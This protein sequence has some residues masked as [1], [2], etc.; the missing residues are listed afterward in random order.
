MARV[1]DIYA[2]RGRMSDAAPYW[3]RMAEVHPGDPNGYLQSAT[4]YWD[5]FDFDS[6]LTQLQKGR[7][8]LA[9]PALY[10]YE[11]GAI[12]ETQGQIAEAIREYAAGSLASDSSVDSRLRFIELAGRPTFRATVD[13][14][15]QGLLKSGT[16]TQA[17]IEL[18]IAVL[19][20]THRSGEVATEL[21]EAISKADSFAVLNMLADTAQTRGLGEVQEAAVN[22]QIALS[23]DPIRKI[24]LQYQLVDLMSSRDA[25]AATQQVDAIYHEHPKVLGV[26]RATVDYDWDHLRRQQAVSVLLEAAQSSYPDLKD[27]FV[28]EAGRKLTDLGDYGRAGKLLSELLARNVMDAGVET[29]LANNYAHSGDKAGLE[30]FYKDRLLVVK[31]SALQG[32]EKADRIAQLRRGMIPAAE[33]LGEWDEVADQYIE[34]IN[35]FPGDADLVQEAALTAG[36]H[37]QGE[38]LTGF[39]RRTIQKS[40]QDARWSIVL[41]ELETGLENFSAAVDAYGLA[42]HVRPEQ[43]DLYSSHAELCERLHRLDVA[44]ADYQ[45]LYRLSYRDP[46]WKI[47]EAEARAR[48]GR[49]ADVVKALEEAWIQGHPAN[50]GDQFRVAQQLEQ[51]N[52]L[53]EARGYAERGADMAGPAWLVDAN[54]RQGAEVYARIMA[55]LRHTDDGFARLAKARYQAEQLAVDTG[56]NSLPDPDSGI[57]IDEWR[58][59]L[60]AERRENIRNVFAV[61]LKAIGTVVAQYDTPEEKLQ[62]S[63]WLQGHMATASD[64][65]ELRS[66][67]LPTIQAAGLK[68]LEVD[69]LWRFALASKT[70]DQSEAQQWLHLQRSRGQIDGG[71]KSLEDLAAKYQGEKRN[72]LLKEALQV[73]Q[74]LNDRT[75]ELRVLTALERGHSGGSLSARHFDLLFGAR[76]ND[77]VARS[78]NDSVA[79]RLVESGRAELAL[80]AIQVRSVGL[81]PVWKSAYTGLV[82][83]YL[84]I[85]QPAIHQGFEDALATEMTIGDRLDHTPERNRQLA[86]DLWYYYGSRYGEYLD[87]EKDPRAEGLLEAALEKAPRDPAA[88]REL[89]NFNAEAGHAEPAL[90]DYR[91]SL[92]LNH[93]QPAVLNSMAVL[94][95]K[96]GDK[97]AAAECWKQAIQLLSAEMDSRRVPESFWDDFAD[98]LEGASAHGSYSEISADVDNMLR[99]Y[100]KRNGSYRSEPLLKAGYEANGQSLSWLLNLA[101]QIREKDDFGYLL[102][103]LSQADWIK[104]EHKTAVLGHIVENLRSRSKPGEEAYELESAEIKWMNALLQDHQFAQARAELSRI[105]PADLNKSGWV[106][107]AL[108]LADADKGLSQILDT[109]KKNPESAPETEELQTVALKLSDA[110]KRALLRYIYEGALDKRQLSTQNFLGLAGV[111]LDEGK[112]DVAVSLL[113]RLTLIGSNMYADTD[114]AAA[115]LEKHGRFVE[116]KPFLQILTEALPWNAG[117]KVRMAVAQLAVDGHNTAA[118]QSL[119][120]VAS[121]QKALYTDRITAAQAMRGRATGTTGSAELD[122]LSQSG[123]ITSEEASKPFYLPARLAAAACSQ[124]AVQRASLLRG[125]LGDAPENMTVR[126]RFVQA[127]L[128]ASLPNLALLAAEPLLRSDAFG[129]TPSYSSEDYSNNEADSR[130][131]EQLPLLKPEERSKMLWLFVKAHEKR[132]E[133]S[134]ALWLLRLM[135][136]DETDSKRSAA[137]QKEQDRIQA[138]IDRAIENSARAP[139][140]HKD[141]EQDHIVR[142][143]LLPGMAFVPKKKAV[144]EEVAE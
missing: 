2:D 82:G 97:K 117:Y 141:L 134:D 102:T 43:K 103:A 24:E 121:D 70:Q 35:S 41:G 9:K 3:N 14:Q 22:R 11:A 138:D 13:A 86:G 66:V 71:G 137:I 52:M 57:N 81:P 19:D 136:P 98:S 118:L 37:N 88:Y 72:G 8:K 12:H 32:S 23:S 5:Y 49:T 91:H 74:D 106:S 142:P 15:T 120:S 42:I 33:Q 95:A 143:R 92:A 65:G 113:K 59:K 39:Y 111:N 46:M 62:F 119:Q 18:R 109:W 4:V 53:D 133:D 54:A 30:K 21:R 140:I 17:A 50:P 56:S 90:D 20:A 25:A 100:L 93:D 48:Q 105:S 47:K 112:N 75:G 125:A 58:N 28:L 51:W 107:I 38:K 44:V 139:S 29:A 96:R 83:L 89:A 99:V 55:R 115:L 104:A 7:E 64:G 6:A 108:Q 60:R 87:E 144:N 122:L 34:L 45:T 76:P 135:L 114:A 31:S 132:G 1:G 78:K 77:L 116:A 10:S 61:A 79:Q 110:G 124:S 27:K 130:K 123:C 67:Y 127:A 63:T 94:Y 126:M 131:P 84:H 129:L 128:D 101:S 68:G 73:Y 40:P 26:V 36:A 69:L 80:S 16:P 85:H